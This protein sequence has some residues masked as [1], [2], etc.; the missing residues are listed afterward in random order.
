MNITCP[1]CHYPITIT[2]EQKAPRF[3]IPEALR[4]EAARN[5]PAHKL[6]EYRAALTSELT[7]QRMDFENWRQTVLVK[8]KQE[9]EAELQAVLGELTNIYKELAEIRRNTSQGGE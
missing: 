2:I 7:Q 9:H 4:F 6:A 5:M 8:L 1:Q 3:E